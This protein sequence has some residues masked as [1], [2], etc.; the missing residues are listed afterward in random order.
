MKP[1]PD[2]Q[3]PPR[4]PYIL[5]LLVCVLWPLLL[6]LGLTH[7]PP[8]EA[9]DP[10]LV[11]DLGHCFTGLVF[12]AA[13]FVFWRMRRVKDQPQEARF[14]ALGRE[15]SM[16]SL[17]FAACSILGLLYYGLAGPAGERHARSFIAVVPIMF[18][19]FVPR[20]LP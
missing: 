18:L 9:S 14:Q 3:L 2:S 20:R 15:T 4:G 6:E 19:V 7:L 10:A 13:A 17:I 16:A 5:G 8:G 11:Q 12:L 1:T